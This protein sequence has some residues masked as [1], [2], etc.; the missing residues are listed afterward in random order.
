VANISIAAEMIVNLRPDMPG[1]FGGFVSYQYKFVEAG[2]GYYYQLY[3]T[4][5]FDSYRNCWAAN[6]FIVLHYKICFFKV[7]YMNEIRL[8]IG[9][10]YQ[11]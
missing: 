8:G 10:K 9:L 2:A 4:D 11:L 1:D 7:E 6:T 5:K 3:S